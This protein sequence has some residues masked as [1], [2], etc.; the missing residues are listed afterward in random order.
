MTTAGIN[1][2]TE[3]RDALVITGV[4]EDGKDA[5]NN[6]VYKDATFTFESGKT[7]MYNGETGGATIINY[8]SDYYARE[9]ANFMTKVNALR[10][11]TFH[12][13]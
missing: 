1:K 2:L 5:N 11:R 6:T 10:L 9:S 8:Y 12:I 7:Y 3:N 4:V 13:I